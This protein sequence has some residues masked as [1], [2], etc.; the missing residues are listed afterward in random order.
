MS[1]QLTDSYHKK[2]KTQSWI[3]HLPQ[4]WAHFIFPQAHRWNQPLKGVSAPK[5]PT[6]PLIN[7]WLP[8]QAIREGEE[9]QIKLGATTTLGS[10]S[11]A[12][13]SDHGN[14]LANDPH[15]RFRLPDIWYA[16]RF[17]L[18]KAHWCVGV[19]IPGIPGV[20]LGMNPNLAWGLPTQEKM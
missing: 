16:T 9:N 11:W 1:E 7:D 5:R 20:I 19:G 18:D 3:T 2:I 15:L 4:S 8:T 12:Y 10:N 13:R 6:P 14:F 17:K